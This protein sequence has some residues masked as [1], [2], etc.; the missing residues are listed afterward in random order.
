[1]TYFCVPENLARKLGFYPVSWTH[2]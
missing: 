1:M 2:S